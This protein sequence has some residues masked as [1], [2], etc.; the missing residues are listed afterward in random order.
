M[1]W[2]AKDAT[3]AINIVTAS[4]NKGLGFNNSYIVSASYDQGSN[5][6]SNTRTPLLKK[7]YY[8]PEEGQQEKIE[9]RKEKKE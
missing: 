2:L 4:M 9:R 3:I 5:I 7:V 6:I 8:N 1:G